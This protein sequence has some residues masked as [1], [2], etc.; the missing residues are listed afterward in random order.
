MAEKWNCSSPHA[1]F[2]VRLLVETSM[3]RASFDS[4]AALLMSMINHNDIA[5]T[6]QWFSIV[7]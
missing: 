6:W 3:P 5:S 1:G 7:I 2:E 4:E